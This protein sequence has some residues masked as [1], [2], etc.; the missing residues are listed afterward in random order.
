MAK[1]RLSMRKTKEILRLRWSQGLSVRETSRSVGVS[2]GVVDKAACRARAAGLTWE[3]VEGLPELELEARLYGTGATSVGSGRAQPDPLYMHKELMRVGVTLELLHLEY[4][5]EHPTGYQY[6][7]FCEAYRR[8]RARKPM[9][10]RQSHKAGEKAF[11]DYSGKKP[12]IVDP[13]TG[14]TIEVELF[15]AALGA[16]SYT[17]VEATRTQRI[18]D[19]LGSHIRMVEFYGGVTTM[20]VPDQLRSAVTTP[21]RYEPGITRSYAQWAQ[22]YGTA[23]VP[24]RPAKP[25]DKAKVEVAVQVAQRWVLARLRNETFFSLEALNER[26][27]ELR[28]D[29]NA[30]PMRAYGGASRRDLFERLDK[31]A[32][33]PLC[34]ERFEIAE[35][36][37]ARVNRDYHFEVKKHLYSAPHALM[38][39]RIETRRTS[40]T[41]EGF[42][43]GQRVCC[44]VRDDTPFQHTTDPL[45]M[46]PQHRHH[47]DGVDSV[48]AWAETVG[49]WTVAMVHAI[50]QANVIREQGFRSARGLQRVG[51]RFGSVRTEAACERA[52]GFGAR[53]YKPVERIL[54]LGRE[55]IVDPRAGEHE[56]PGIQ[57][58]N[59]RGPDYYH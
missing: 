29:L 15:V 41:T 7:S 9:W 22:H 19:W 20:V 52:V 26:I 50:I 5:Q 53:S 33:R 27:R 59:V 34:E 17:Y 47:A 40:T 2:T 4:L 45:H 30:R 3:Q 58:E 57:H 56:S 36:G 31:P 21:C 13:T 48:L 37:E 51:E 28:D 55:T 18:E 1:E 10:M 35:W 43:R 38:G 16:S 12:R 49:P 39:E 46:P 24:A 14:E 32:L 25:K 42:L 54:R 23:I 6:T 8:W 11:T 44:H